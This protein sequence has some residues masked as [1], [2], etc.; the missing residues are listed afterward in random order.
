MCCRKRYEWRTS[1]TQV[2]G[3][4]LHQ[5]I[6]LQTWTPDQWN[7]DSLPVNKLICFLNVY[8]FKIGIIVGLGWHTLMTHEGHRMLLSPRNL[9]M[10]CMLLM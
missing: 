4:D 7:S 5:R 8:I 3:I 9:G 2:S 1:A 10:L 6:S